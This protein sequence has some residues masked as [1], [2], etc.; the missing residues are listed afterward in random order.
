MYPTSKKRLLVV[1]LFGLLPLGCGPSRIA[2]GP[3]FMYGGGGG[4]GGGSYSRCD[5]CGRDHECPDCSGWWAE[6]REWQKRQA[7]ENL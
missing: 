7:Q 6:Y 3:E 5:K 1:L 4:G 2:L